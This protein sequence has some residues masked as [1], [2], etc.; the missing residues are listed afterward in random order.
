MSK[1]F[2]LDELG[3][4]RDPA[5]LQVLNFLNIVV[6]KAFQEEKYSQIGRLPKFFLASEKR[7]I[8]NQDLQSWPGYEACTKWYNDGIFLN[9]D[10]A[11][12]FINSRTVY[13]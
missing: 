9:V 7:L 8:P 5:H 2:N 1:E 3:E 10:T 6:K 12:K 13:D 4:D 11:T